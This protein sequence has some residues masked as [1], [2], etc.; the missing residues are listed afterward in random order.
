MA[1]GTLILLCIF[2]G[3]ALVLAFIYFPAQYGAYKMKRATRGRQETQ[4][5]G[6]EHLIAISVSRNP[7][8]EQIEQKKRDSLNALKVQLEQI[9]QR[10]QRP[11]PSIDQ[12]A[13]RAFPQP[14]AQSTAN[15][16]IKTSDDIMARHRVLVDKFLE[17]SER[18]VSVLDEYGDEHWDALADEI[19]RC[20]AKIALQEPSVDL[21]KWNN[22]KELRPLGYRDVTSQR[23][24]YRLQAEFTAYHQGRKRA[25]NGVRDFSKLTGVDFEVYVANRLKEAGFESVAGTPATGDQGADLIAKRNGKTIA[26]QAKGYSGTVGNGAVQEIVGALRFYKADEGWVVTNSTFTPSARALAQVNNI[27]LIDGHD[28]GTTAL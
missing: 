17:I 20:V 21:S 8:V 7:L 5:T 11:N 13:Q 23:L 26:I 24:W 27:R 6:T 10:T 3:V 25:P 9:G 14:T 12:I 16:V 15:T 1:S 18:K 28:L 22:S 19:E 2:A 4:G